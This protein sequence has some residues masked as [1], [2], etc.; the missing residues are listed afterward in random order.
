MRNQLYPAL[1]REHGWRGSTAAALQ[2]ARH[3]HDQWVRQFIQHVLARLERRTATGQSSKTAPVA[4]I[5][6][7]THVVDTS[8][9]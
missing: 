9:G 3:A 4:L 2:T 5:P 7:D 8:C 1:N 6:A